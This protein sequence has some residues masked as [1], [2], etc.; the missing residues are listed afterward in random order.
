MGDFV[1]FLLGCMVSGTGIG[2]FVVGIKM[3]LAIV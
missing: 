2:V 1:L 3:I